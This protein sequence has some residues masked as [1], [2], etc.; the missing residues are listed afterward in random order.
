MLKFIK[1]GGTNMNEVII[2]SL[3]F[4]YWGDKLIA[5]SLTTLAQDGCKRYFFSKERNR[6]ADSFARKWA[7]TA[8]ND[9]TE[10]DQ[11]VIE[12]KLKR[13]ANV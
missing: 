1:Y 6:E 11:K 10:V 13:V 9:F 3:K 12:A 2:D 5:C 4:L 7:Q 8:I